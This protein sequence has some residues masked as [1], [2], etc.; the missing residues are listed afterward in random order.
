[1]LR[2]PRRY[3]HFVFAVVQSG[4]TSA[5]AAAVACAPFLEESTFLIHWFASWLLAW[6]IMIPIVLLAAPVIRRIVLAL[7]VAAGPD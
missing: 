7:T 3:G 1:M 2:I 6:A 4:M 5:V